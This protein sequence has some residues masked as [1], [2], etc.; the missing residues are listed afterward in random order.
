MNTKK[1][2][3]INKNNNELDKIASPNISRTFPR[4]R[5][6]R[7]WENKPSVCKTSACTC[8]FLPALFI[9]TK[10]IVSC[11]IKSPQNKIIKPRINGV[12]KELKIL[13]DGT[14]SIK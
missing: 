6:L 1:G 7:L 10:P 12:K 11:L 8:L 14:K 5:G 9:F 3:I 4:Y 13:G 2:N